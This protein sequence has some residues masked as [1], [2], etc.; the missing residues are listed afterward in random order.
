MIGIKSNK[1]K[2]RFVN[3]HKMPRTK[4]RQFSINNFPPVDQHLRH[5]PAYHDPHKLIPY[6][7]FRTGT[8]ADLENY[9]T[10]FKKRKPGVR[11]RVMPR[12]E[13]TTV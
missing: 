12:I 3:K 10:G 4:P 13:Q 2:T 1:T 7:P 8:I 5:E 6:M 11:T 9:Y